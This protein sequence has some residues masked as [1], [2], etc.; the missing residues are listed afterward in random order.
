MRDDRI[1]GTGYN[2]T[3]SGMLNCD[4]GGCVLCNDR[5]LEK[6]GRESEMSDPTHTA[7]QALDRCICVHA[8]Q[9]ALL[10]AARFGIAVEGSTLYTTLSPCFTCLK[11]AVQAGVMRIVYDETYNA[12]YSEPVQAQY[13]RMTDV[14]KGK[15]EGVGCAGFE[16]LAGEHPPASVMAPPDP[17]ETST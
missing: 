16:A 11:E 13:S 6:Q 8:E 5:W 9:N 15:S 7:G 17:V 12:A 2:G 1:I 3:P 14:L 10:T 4:E